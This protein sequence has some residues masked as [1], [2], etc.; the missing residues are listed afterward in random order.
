SRGGA[1]RTRVVEPGGRFPGHRVRHGQGGAIGHDGCHLDVIG[2][3]SGQ[4][5][6]GREFASRGG[7]RGGGAR[8]DS[9]SCDRAGT[10]WRTSG[11]GTPGHSTRAAGYW[12]TA[13]RLLSR[14]LA[15]GPADGF[16]ASPAHASSCTYGT[17]YTS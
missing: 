2:Q 1:G 11:R 8:L 4:P 5:L 6:S 14:P 15:G 12:P 10:P 7:S 16:D 13:A 17:I 3:L 9:A